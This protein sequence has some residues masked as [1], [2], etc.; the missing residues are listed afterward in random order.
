[1]GLYVGGHPA[2]SAEDRTVSTDGKILGQDIKWYF[3]KETKTIDSDTTVDV[4]VEVDNEDYPLYMHIFARPY[5]ESAWNE[6]KQM[7]E[8]LSK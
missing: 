8:S 5:T 2:F 7:S 3:N 1:M 6:F 4:L